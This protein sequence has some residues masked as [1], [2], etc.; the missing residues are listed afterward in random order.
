MTREW[1]APKAPDLT[2]P[3]PRRSCAPPTHPSMSTHIHMTCTCAHTDTDTDTQTQTSWSPSRIWA[4]ACVDRAGA[5]L[6][7]ACVRVGGEGEWAAGSGRTLFSSGWFSVFR[8]PFPSCLPPLLPRHSPRHT[9]A[10]RAGHVGVT[11]GG[12]GEEGKRRERERERDLA[13]GVEA[14]HEKLPAL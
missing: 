1:W 13:V 10:S 12:E 2:L 3:T 4:C 9:L 14:P 11:R 6:I 5:C 8:D 7:C